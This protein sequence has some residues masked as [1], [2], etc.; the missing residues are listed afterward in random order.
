M[1]SSFKTTFSKKLFFSTVIQLFYIYIF[2]MVPTV[3]NLSVTI[4]L[5]NPV[6]LL[7]SMV[8]GEREEN[9]KGVCCWTAED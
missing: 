6:S 8:K 9:T 1:H 2:G 7:E 4:Q 3:I 5:N